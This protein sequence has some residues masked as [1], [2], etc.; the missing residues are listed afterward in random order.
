MERKWIHQNRKIY[1]IK[2]KPVD[3]Q[4]SPRSISCLCVAIKGDILW[5][6][7]RLLYQHSSPQMCLVLFCWLAGP[8][9]SAGIFCCLSS[10]RPQRWTGIRASLT[11]IWRHIHVFSRVSVWMHF[12][13][14]F[15]LTFK[16]TDR[17]LY[18]S[19]TKRSGNI[20]SKEAFTLIKRSVASYTVARFHS[21]TLFGRVF[22][23]MCLIHFVHLE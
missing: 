12:N 5:R 18:N 4:N 22:I 20:A 8:A 7:Q 23:F 19:E 14:S 2:K 3:F 10:V 16:T 1:F 15:F 13:R 21:S 6:K 11:Y 17:I 9:G